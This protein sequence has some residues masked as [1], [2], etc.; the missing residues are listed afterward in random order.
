MSS[1]EGSSP[2]N[3]DNDGHGTEAI[4]DELNLPPY[5]KVIVLGLLCTAIFLDVFNSTALSTALPVISVQLKISN[6]ES[7]W[8]Y[9]AY[10]LTFSAALLVCGR[11]SDLYNPKSVFV[12]GSSTLSIFT[13]IAG[14]IRKKIP[15]I[16]LRGLMGCGAA[17][18]IPSAQHLIV[19]M[20]PDPASQAKALSTFAS[21]GGTGLVLGLFIGAVLVE[22]AS[23]P[24]IFYFGAI[25][26]GSVTILILLLVPNLRQHRSKK[27]QADK[28]LRLKR[29]DLPGITLFTVGLLLFIFAVTSGSS[30]GWGSAQVI[31]PLVLSVIL[32]SGFV[33]WE[34]YI[35]EEDAALPPKI[36]K[37]E[38]V[39]ILIAIAFVPFMWWSSLYPLFSLFWQLVDGWSPMKVAIH[40]L[41]IV[42]GMIPVA[43]FTAN[44]PPNVPAKW[45]IF[46]GCVLL[47]IANA[48]LPFNTSPDTYW[49]FGLPGFLLGTIGAATVYS[50]TNIVLLANTP[51]HI[52]GV[53]SALFT[54]A[55]QTGAAFG[56]A[57]VTSIQ[58]SVEIHH[59][60]PS[61]FNGRAAGLWFLMA[62]AAVSAASIPIFMTSATRQTKPADTIAEDK[63]EPES[64]I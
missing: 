29:L 56:L 63:L 58:T 34:A 11:I 10:Q 45:V 41:P 52:S 6:S 20:F 35:P 49:R 42:L 3:Q 39:A 17:L 36:W 2:V 28:K 5:R 53:V 30:T 59:G 19:H 9:G 25:T 12:I 38:N 44:I 50:M 54:A 22:F 55:G 62:V 33:I 8:L 47:L 1:E 23:W 51:A 61:K 21:F 43:P 40:F 14:F 24:W 27:T 57:I 48:V 64:E 4:I 13:L 46:M 60:G 31:A 32:V 26:C 18:T 37:Y 7:V 16:I 15:L